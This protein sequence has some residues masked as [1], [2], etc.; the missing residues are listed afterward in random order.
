[1]AA[2]PMLHRQLEPP[3]ELLSILSEGSLEAAMDRA[4]RELAS[5]A[6]AE[7]AV[8]FSF[9]GKEIEGEFWSLAPANV[10]SAVRT[11]FYVAAKAALQNREAIVAPDQGAAAMAPRVRLAAASGA[12]RAAVCFSPTRTS[13]DGEDQ[14]RI[15]TLLQLVALRL[16]AHQEAAQSKALYRWFNTLDEQLRVLDRERQ[17]FA[18]IVHRSDARV[19]V[20]D[21]SRTISWTNS[22]MGSPP[23]PEAGTT[24]IG[25]SCRDVCSTFGQGEQADCGECPVSQALETN[26]VVHSEF[27]QSDPYGTRDLY[28]SALPIKGPDGRPHEAMV[29]IQ[30]LSDLEVIR[31]SE[32]RYRLLFERSGKAIIVVEPGTRRILLVNPMASRMTGYSSDELHNLALEALYPEAEWRLLEREYRSAFERGTL[33]THECR[34]RTREGEERLAAVSGTRYDLEGQEAMMLEFQDITETKRVAEALEKAEQRLRTVVANAPIALFA[35]DRDGKFT[36]LEGKSLEALGVEP[37]SVVGRSVYELYGDANEIPEEVRRAL[38]GEEINAVIR[39]GRLAFEASSTPLKDAN[40][41]IMGVIGVATDVTDRHRLEEQLRHSQRME[42]IG[43]LAGGVAHDFN[44]MLA[45]MLGHSEMMIAKL[46]PDHHLRRNAEE[47]RKAAERGALLTRQLLA[48]S[49]KEVL[50]PVI[51]DVNTVLAGMESMLRGLIG[52]DIELATIRCKSPAVVKVDCGQ[53]QQVI[54][55]MV[56]NARD[57]MPKGGRLTLEV[58]CVTLDRNYAQK[59]PG[60]TPGPH[61][62]VSVCDTGCG[63]DPET[64]SHIF[65]PFFTTKTRGKGTG[66]GLSTVYGIVEQCGGHLGVYTEPAIGT[67]FKVYLPRVEQAPE[68]IPTPGAA[69]PAGSGAETVLLVEDEESVRSMVSD[70]L[71]D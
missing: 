7:A 39:V 59:H 54:M 2:E 11:A 13:P 65:E 22:V 21:L 47:I 42:A 43:R 4:V 30:D 45:T 8:L 40:G 61:V 60:V 26:R 70:L 35:L 71:I 15:A 67:T 62:M 37:G 12:T 51:L 9:D 10:P 41:E 49:R 58:A 48:F 28:L 64:L 44:N 53:F 69:H 3:A 36:L 31:R 63:M 66:L 56:V 29:M 25:L 38:A 32:S 1:M 27:R 68:T 46:E 24:W 14:S 19:F 5:A 33:S 20:T 57:A 6:N 34:V 55:N 16:A 52:E 18:A 17:K 23:R 50:A